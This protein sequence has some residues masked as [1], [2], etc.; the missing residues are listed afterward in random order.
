LRLRLKPV[1]ALDEDERAALRALTA[2]V[3]PPEV[4]AASPGRHVTWS[5]PDFSLMVSTDEGELVSHVGILVREGSLDGGPVRIGGIGSVKT[6]PRVQ[7]RGYA[8]AGLRQAAATLHDEHQVAFSLL[9]CQEH[10]LA[11][12]ARLSW[13]AFAGRLVVAQPAG[14]MVFTI[15]RP[16]VLAGRRPAPA[17]G[18]IDLNGPPW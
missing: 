13:L 6:H 9:V 11:F 7:G 8:S 1:A 15:N 12:Y 5:P 18:T 17:D 4:V 10:L 14:S 2:A 16:M 3:Y